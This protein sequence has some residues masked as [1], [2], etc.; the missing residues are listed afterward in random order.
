[1]YD[2]LVNRLRRGMRLECQ[3]GQDQQRQ[4][5]SFKAL[6]ILKHPL[7]GE[8]E[9]ARFYNTA[10]IGVRTH[11]YIRISQID[12]VR[13]IEHAHRDHFEEA[14]VCVDRAGEITTSRPRFP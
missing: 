1:M 8:L 4:S 9:H 14:G 13:D 11:L 5:T 6:G 12:V 3:T 2:D 7:Q 10:H